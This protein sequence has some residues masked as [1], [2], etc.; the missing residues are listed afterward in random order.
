M[1]RALALAIAGVILLLASP[2]I[3]EPP[4]LEVTPITEPVTLRADSGAELR[5]P[6]GFFVPLPL[7]ETLDQEVRRLQDAETRLGAENRSLRASLDEGPGWGTVAL[8][9]LTLAAGI[10]AGAIMY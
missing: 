10:A 6:P 3:A 5:L 4:T 1:K 8:V 7:W 9:G 2:A